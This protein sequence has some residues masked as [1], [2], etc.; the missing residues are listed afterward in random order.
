MDKKFEQV[1]HG[2]GASS[3]VCFLDT[4][5]TTNHSQF[6][7]YY[8]KVIKNRRVSAASRI[9]HGMIW[10][11]ITIDEMYR[12]LGILLRISLEPCDAGGYTAYCQDSNT[13][14]YLSEDKSHY[15]E[16]P[17]TKGFMTSISKDFRMSLNPSNK[18]EVPF[19]LKTRCL[20]MEKRINVIWKR[21]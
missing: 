2:C 10:R 15:V 6:L 3:S 18:F 19:T 7:S 4:T 13:C 9:W 1:S 8:H 5:P 20:Q 16:I 14:V 12:F 11:D 21:G 17:E